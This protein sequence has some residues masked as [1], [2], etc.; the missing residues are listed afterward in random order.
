MKALVWHGKQ[1]IRCDN[2]PDPEI[3]DPKDA[4]IK[5]TSCA[6]CG[7]DL[8]LFDGVMP[9]MLKGDVLGHETM[10][11]VVE[12][13]PENRK[14]KVGDR[15]VVPFTISC[16]ECFFAKTD[17]SPAASDPIRFHRIE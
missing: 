9:S 13:G 14:L 15:V 2:V 11:E 7:S 1:D 10:G 17:S 5:V 8:H 3:E 12:V 6:I 4:V 16:G